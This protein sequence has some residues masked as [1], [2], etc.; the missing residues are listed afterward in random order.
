MALRSGH[1]ESQ[2]SFHF[3]PYTVSLRRKLMPRQNLSRQ[4]ILEAAV[5]LIDENGLEALSMRRLAQSLD[6]EAMSLYRHVKNKAALLDGIHETILSEIAI[7]PDASVPW[8]EALVML[9][10]AFRDVMLD[11]PAALPLFAARPAVTP[12]SLRY[13]DR[14]LRVLDRSNL[15][16]AHVISAFQTLAAFV[17]GHTSLTHG[18]HGP[19]E[20]TLPRYADSELPMVTKYAPAIETHDD[21]EDFTFGLDALLDGICSHT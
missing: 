5:A 3:E 17:I 21:D 12:G 14:A 10:V 19:T 6:V 8:R 20:A 7:D 11:H 2:L 9:A 16:D 1:P 13:V 15:S 18:P 4:R